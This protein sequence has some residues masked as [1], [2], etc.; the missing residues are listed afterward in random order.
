MAKIKRDLRKKIELFPYDSLNTEKKF[1]V[2]EMPAHE[3]PREKL[4]TKGTNGMS[5]Y[6]LLAIILRTGIKGHNVLDFSQKLLMHFGSLEKLFDA[7]LQ[8][9]M[10]IKG[11][12]LAKG[13]EIVSCI[14]LAKRFRKERELNENLRLQRESIND[15]SAAVDHIREMITDYSKEQ[16]FVLNL[17]VR[18]RIIDV[19]RIS[20]GTL[21]ASLVHPR[22]TFE[23]AIRKHS[24]SIMVAHNHPSGDLQPSEEDIRITRRLKD[25]GN[26]LGI[27]LLDHIIITKQKYSS[28]KEMGI[29]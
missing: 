18:N 21:T 3:K 25:A 16:F 14:T 28:L 26:I 12:G 7:S 22:E 11:I 5:D 20:E 17:D 4:L 2:K 29:I 19:D 24:A 15:A 8:D 23:S 1:S 6:E 9:L 27:Q 10:E 13:S